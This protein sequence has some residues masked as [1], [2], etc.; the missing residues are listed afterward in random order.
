VLRRAQSA[1]SSRMQPFF[2]PDVSGSH[3]S[4]AKQPPHCGGCFAVFGYVFRRSQNL[5]RSPIRR[6][7]WLLSSAGADE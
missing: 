4:K 2:A 5:C 1:L 7:F 6:T 3:R